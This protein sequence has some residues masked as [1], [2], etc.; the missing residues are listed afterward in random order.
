MCVCVREKESES[1]IIVDC[2]RGDFVSVVEGAVTK[3]Y[4]CVFECIFSLSEV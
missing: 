2:G 3:L 1:E 4:K